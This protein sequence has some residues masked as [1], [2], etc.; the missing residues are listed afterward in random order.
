[1]SITYVHSAVKVLEAVALRPPLCLTEHS[2]FW[3][4]FSMHNVVVKDVLDVPSMFRVWVILS[5]CSGMLRLRVG[6]VVGQVWKTVHSTVT[7]F[8]TIMFPKVVISGFSA[9]PLQRK[10]KELLMTHEYTSIYYVY[11]PNITIMTYPLHY[12]SCIKESVGA[13]P[14]I[15]WIYPGVNLQ[16]VVRPAHWGDLKTACHAV[17]GSQ[18]TCFSFKNGN[19]I[20]RIPVVIY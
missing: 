12:Y 1:M 7:Q 16:S 8:P 5:S 14:N 6:A 20:V 3:C 2:T 9:V 19:D 13:C 10:C 4:S 11:F 15:L 17:C 18:Y